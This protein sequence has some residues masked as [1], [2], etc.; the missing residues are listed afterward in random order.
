MAALGFIDV[1]SDSILL[2]CHAYLLDEDVDNFRNIISSLD[3]LR[4]LFS[5]YCVPFNLNFKAQW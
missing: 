1:K 2:F 3:I 5:H 4:C